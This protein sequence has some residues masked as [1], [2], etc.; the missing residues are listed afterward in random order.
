MRALWVLLNTIESLHQEI[1]MAEEFVDAVSE[2]LKC[3]LCLENVNQP[4]TFPCLHNF[5]GSCADRL[6]PV[7]R[8]DQSGYDCPM[9]RQFAPMD[10]IKRS[11][12]VINQLVDVITSHSQQ[13]QVDDDVMCTRCRQS[14]AQWQCHQCDQW[15]SDSSDASTVTSPS[16]HGRLLRRDWPNTRPRRPRQCCM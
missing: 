7:T 5:C 11:N 3:P 4:C 13:A 10:T 2:I 9:C 12:F 14:Q 8:D 1:V 16:G 15:L 6:E